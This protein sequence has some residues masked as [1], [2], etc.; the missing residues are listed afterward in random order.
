MIIFNHLLDCLW[1][2]SKGIMAKPLGPLQQDGVRNIANAALT[3]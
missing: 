1:Y 2:C 3:R